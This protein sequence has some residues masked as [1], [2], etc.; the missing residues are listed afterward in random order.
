MHHT[1]LK[2]LVADRFKRTLYSL[3]AV[4]CD[5]SLLKLVLRL[6]DTHLQRNVRHTIGRIIQPVLRACQSPCGMK[7]RVERRGGERCEHA[8]HWHYWRPSFSLL[9]CT[10]RHTGRVLV[11]ASDRC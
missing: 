2:R 5:P 10:L 8:E 3:R 9:N 4:C 11:P 1:L 6:R 7:T